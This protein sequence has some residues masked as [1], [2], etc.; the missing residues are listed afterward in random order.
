MPDS[1]TVFGSTYTGVT[2]FK[3]TD[4]NSN[5]LTYIRPQGNKTISQNGSDIDVAEYATVSVNVSGGGGTIVSK[6]ITENGTYNA[7]ADNADG[8][9]PV[10]VNVP[11]AFAI[12]D[13]SN[14][15]GTTAQITAGAGNEF[16]YWQTTLDTVAAEIVSSSPNYFT[17]NGYT[18][19]FAENEVYR[20]TLNDV[21]YFRGTFAN[22]NAAI[23]DGYGVGQTSFTEVPFGM[24][25]SAYTENQ[26]IVLTSLPAGQ[27]TL[28]I[29]KL[30]TS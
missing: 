13:V 15:T 23:A 28:K 5:T 9:S 22:S 24:Y 3:A 1:L 4:T 8:Y 7:S 18:T 11:N 14:T 26:L 16:A 2:G 19:P 29:E 27:C 20:V 6:S 30:I 17:V 10:T 12:S 21:E 25:R